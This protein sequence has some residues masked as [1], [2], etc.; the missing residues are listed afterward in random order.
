MTTGPFSSNWST[1]NQSWFVELWSVS[2]DPPLRRA[3][4]R[5]CGGNL[6]T[7]SLRPWVVHRISLPIC[8]M[9]ELLRLGS[10]TFLLSLV[11]A[12][13][14]LLPLLSP[15]IHCLNGYWSSTVHLLIL[16]RMHAPL[17]SFPLRYSKPS[18]RC[19]WVSGNVLVLDQG[20]SSHGWIPRT[21]FLTVSLFASAIG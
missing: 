12:S 1:N 14:I 2:P 17:S 5:T 6:T 4:T 11:T 10:A 16:I 13:C 21:M 18:G 8:E 20:R 9:S 7:P 19:R 3:C 15:L